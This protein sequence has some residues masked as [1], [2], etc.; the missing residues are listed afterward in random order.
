M[1]IRKAVSDLLGTG[2]TQ[3]QLAIEAD[4][5]QSLISALFSGKRGVR[6]SYGIAKRIEELHAAKVGTY[7][8][9]ASGESK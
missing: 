8:G 9:G 2:L 3:S 4:C 6:P 7:V 1:D 5:S